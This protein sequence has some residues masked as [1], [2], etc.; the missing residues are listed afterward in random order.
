MLINLLITHTTFCIFPYLYLNLHDIKHSC[1]SCFL[2]WCHVMNISHSIKYFI[3]NR[4]F[5]LN[6]SS[7]I[8]SFEHKSLFKPKDRFLE[9]I[10]KVSAFKEF[11]SDLGMR[12]GWG[13]N[14]RNH[15]HTG[16]GLDNGDRIPGAKIA[17]IGEVISGSD[18]FAKMCLDTSP[19]VLWQ[20]VEYILDVPQ[21]EWC[22]L[23][24]SYPKHGLR[25]AASEIWG[26][27]PMHNL[28]PCPTPR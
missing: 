11:I 4:I 17:K 23:R 28:R 25:P 3:R 20:S 13:D 15:C 18:R 21:K 19:S 24:P 2:T 9:H 5:L 1:V 16:V 26:L 10:I 6:Q 12:V 8:N 7:E 14:K 22:S 27:L